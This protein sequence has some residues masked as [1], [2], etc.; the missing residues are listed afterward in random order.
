VTRP[1][2]LEIEWL[3]VTPARIMAGKKGE[4]LFFCHFK[5]AIKKVPLFKGDFELFAK[6]V[7]SL[8]SVTV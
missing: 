5:G 2:A 1:T 3:P 6:I 7:K 4:D 8:H